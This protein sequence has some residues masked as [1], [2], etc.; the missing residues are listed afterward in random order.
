MILDSGFQIHLMNFNP[1]EL[2]LQ[3]FTKSAIILYTLKIEE[4]QRHL[5]IIQ[6]IHKYHIPSRI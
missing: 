2:N 3:K 4:I 6:R 1:L 5:F